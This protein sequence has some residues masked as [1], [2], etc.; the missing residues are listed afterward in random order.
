MKNNNYAG[1]RIE[2]RYLLREDF[3]LELYPSNNKIKP[4][5]MTQSIKD[6]WQGKT[7]ILPYSFKKMI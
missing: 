1:K 4:L 3:E 7:Q 6:Y 2:S 5:K